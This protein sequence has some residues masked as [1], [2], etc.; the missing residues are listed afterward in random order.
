MEPDN[1][2]KCNNYIHEFTQHFQ[3][4]INIKVCIN[5][6]SKAASFNKISKMNGPFIFEIR[7]CGPHLR[8]FIE[9]Y[10]ISEKL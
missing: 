10:A 5:K 2:F 9:K 1:V 7:K 6:T 4:L 3:P 8:I